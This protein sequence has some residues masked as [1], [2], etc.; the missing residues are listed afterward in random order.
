MTTIEAVR[1]V[2]PGIN[3]V[4]G[5]L[6]VTGSAPYP[7]DFSFANM[8]YAVLVRATVAAGRIRRIEATAAEAAPG[9]LAV[10]TH[11]N[12]PHLER[13]PDT[14]VWRQPPPPLQDDRIVHY[15]QYIGV[16][17]AETAEQAAAAAWLIETDYEPA[18]PLLDLDDPRAEVLANPWGTDAHRGDVAAGLA[19]ADVTVDVTY[20]TPDETNN[21]MGLFATVAAWDGDSLTSTTRP[22]GPTASGRRSR[23]PSGSPKAGS[24]CSR[25]SS[26]AGSA[27]DCGSG[28]TLS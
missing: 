1:L 18:E 24:G 12:A 14:P 17:V 13:G 10:I 6:K 8:A 15:G 20:T 27:P 19:S 11:R 23:R 26:G 21:P 25:R 22:S 3:R 2:G 16:V 4:D 28:R 7:G 9:V 5:P